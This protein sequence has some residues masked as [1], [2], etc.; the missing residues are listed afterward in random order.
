[1]EFITDLWLPTLLS[2][3]AVFFASFLAWAVL[4][5]HKD[6]YQQLPDENAFCDVLRRANLPP[7]NYAFP[8]HKCFKSH[9]DPEYTKRWME[10]PTGTLSVWPRPNMGRNMVL[11]F[12]VYLVVSLLIAYIARNT[13]ANGADFGRVFRITATAG[14]LAYAFAFLPNAIW[15][16][17]PR[18]ATVANVVEGV[19][20]GLMTGLLFAAMWPDAF[21]RLP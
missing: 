21:I 7:G 3:V 9:K 14:I 2:A 20:Y 10:G 12:M 15:F 11:T 17:H 5:I 4:P 19:V 13:L 18:R 1:M 8:H 6:D 16:S